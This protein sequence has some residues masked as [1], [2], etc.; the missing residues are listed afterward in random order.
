MSWRLAR[1]RNS[2]REG[3]TDCVTAQRYVSSSETASSY[4]NYLCYIPRRKRLLY[5]NTVV[6]P[7][8]VSGQQHLVLNAITN[9]MRQAVA[10]YYCGITARYVLGACLRLFSCDRLSLTPNLVP[11]L[12]QLMTMLYFCPRKCCWLP[13]EL[14]L[15]RASPTSDRTLGSGK[16]ASLV[17]QDQQV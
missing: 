1:L 8:M 11:L 5:Y 7:H 12:L 3:S 15:G 13:P 14:L 9:Q 4:V 17:L 2:G 10:S 6:V 16:R